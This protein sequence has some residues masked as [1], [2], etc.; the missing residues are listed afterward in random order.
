MRRLACLLPLLGLAACQPQYDDLRF[1]E[2]RNRNPQTFYISSNEIQVP[3][4]IAAAV[5]VEPEERGWKQYE[6]FHLVELES[7]QPSV[8]D[9]RP[10]PELDQWVFLG[11]APGVTEVQV[12][13]RGQVV[14]HIQ[15]EV[16]P[17]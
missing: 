11:R 15:A 13:I 2:V 7:R 9:V 3:V 12:R 1:S 17:Q 5:R 10:G 8:L 16:V 14:D 6:E 4:G